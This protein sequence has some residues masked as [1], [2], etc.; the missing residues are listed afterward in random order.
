MNHGLRARLRLTAGLALTPISLT[1]AAQLLPTLQVTESAPDF[2]AFAGA[3]LTA[4]VAI[5]VCA[6]V[7]VSLRMAL[8]V[9]AFAAAVLAGV[10]HSGA[11]SLTSLVVVDSALVSLAWGLGASLGRRVQ[12]ASHLFPACV[13]AASADVVSLL[14]PEGPSHA[15]AESDRALSVLAMGFPVAGSHAVAPVLGVGDLLFT[16]FVLG[17]AHAHRLSYAR[18]IACI[19]AGVAAA[20]FAAARLGVA[21]PALVTIAAAIIVGMPAIRR[22]RAVDRT[23]AHASMAIA[24]SLVVVTL[25]RTA[26]GY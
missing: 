25:A 19:G 10:A 12:H 15:I 16:A 6:A 3:T 17:I 1:L 13:V 7:E 23:A 24:L 20:G 8:G 5:A 26:L 14:S 9:A 21:V 11:S 2:I 18:A 4:I 22:L